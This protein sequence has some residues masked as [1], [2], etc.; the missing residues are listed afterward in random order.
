[1]IFDE[2]DRIDLKRF[3]WSPGAAEQPSLF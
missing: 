1:V 3:G 2:K